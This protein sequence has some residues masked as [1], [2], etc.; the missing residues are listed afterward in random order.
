MILGVGL[1]V[2]VKPD[3]FPESLREIAGSLGD[4]SFD[5]EAFAARILNALA[6]FPEEAGRRDFLKEYKSRSLLLGREIEVARGESVQSA[7]A[8]DIDEA[9]R[10][11]VRL[12][13]GGVLALD[14]GEARARLL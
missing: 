13:S 11:V 10:L 6:R 8:L 4:A 7:V 1:N 9:A 2:S 14:S 5:K 3:E 12:Q